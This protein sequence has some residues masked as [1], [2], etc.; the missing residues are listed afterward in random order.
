MGL[1][2]L[3]EHA[4][5]LVEWSEFPSVQY[6][7]GWEV[8]SRDRDRLKENFS[9]VMEEKRFTLWRRKQKGDTE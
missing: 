9:L 3:I 4:P 6:V 7:L 5:S 2:V 1:Y 8:A